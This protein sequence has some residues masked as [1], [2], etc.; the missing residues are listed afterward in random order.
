MKDVAADNFS[1]SAIAKG[2]KDIA[3]AGQHLDYLMLEQ[4]AGIRS[5]CTPEQ[6][7]K[8]DEGWMKMYRKRSPSKKK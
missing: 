1:D 5:I 8:F 2:S 4:A 6:L 3:E 7:P